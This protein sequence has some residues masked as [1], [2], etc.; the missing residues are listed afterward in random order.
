MIRRIAENGSCVIV[1]RAADYILRGHPD[2]V[3]VFIYAP[4]EYRIAK[5]ME[6]YGDTRA[7]AE[8]NIRRSDDARAAYYKSISG[9]DWG[10]RRHY[11]L[12]VDSSIGAEASAKIVEEYI[13]GFEKSRKKHMTT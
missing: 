2:V 4:E 1:G 8:K 7:E 11:D 13:A 10:D 5:V 6:V 9:S 3:R 12:M